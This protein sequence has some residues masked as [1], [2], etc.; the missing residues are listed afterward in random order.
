MRV[1]AV[2]VFFAPQSIGGA[3]RVVE[4]NVRDFQASNRTNAVGVFC[5]LNG[6]Q[7][8]E[9]SR[10]YLVNGVPVQSI[11]TRLVENAD[12]LLSD[13]TNRKRFSEFLDYFCPDII[14]FHCVQR[15]TSDLALE[16]KERGIPYLITMHDGWWI[17]DR[18]FLVNELGE[19]ETYNY[20]D[21]EDT[22]ERL[23]E[24]ALKR[25][26]ALKPA[27]E[28][29]S[30]LLTVSETFRTIV[31]ESGLQNVG[32]IQNGVSPMAV[33]P[34]PRA[35]KITLGYLAGAAHYKGY[36]FMRAA[37]TKGQFDNLRLIVVDH[38]LRQEQSINEYWGETEVERIGFVPQDKVAELYQRLHVVL[39]P[40]IWPESFGLVAREA[41]LSRA[42]LVASNRGA[43]AE[44]IEEGVNGHVFDP[45]VTGDFER[46]LSLLN[47]DIAR[48]SA[49]I[50]EPILKTSAQQ[51]EELLDLY[52]SILS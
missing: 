26:N 7:S 15:L 5:S 28:G 44:D 13:R 47:T 3:T 33:L 8:Q 27:L 19:V 18:Q 46:V 2:N 41:L 32:V 25:M 20:N 11:A 6:A 31:E 49:A 37:I 51:S 34:K 42:W 45:G 52:N 10:H 4:D 9:I 14:H 16:A 24:K 39:V 23:G 35:D 30:K 17:S 1:L 22:L 38:S 43:A 29:A 48:Y 21:A 40:S 12:F 50:P 36:H